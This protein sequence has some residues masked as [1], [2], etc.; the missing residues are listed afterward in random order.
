M[1]EPTSASSTASSPVYHS[2][3]AE[4]YGFGIGPTSLTFLGLGV[5]AGV[6]AVIIVVFA[7]TV[8][9]N[10]V[11]ASMKAGQGDPRYLR[12]MRLYPAMIGGVCLTI[13]LFWFAWST[14]EGVHWMCPVVAEAVYGLGN[15]LVFMSA[16]LYLM[17]FYG[18]MY[19]ASAMA[20][21]TLIRYV[22]GA[23]FPLFI[24]PMFRNLG[25]GWAVSI[26]WVHQFAV[27]H[28]ALYVLHSGTKAAED[29]QVCA[30]QLNL[31]KSQGVC[32]CTI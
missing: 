22:I 20:G 25:I 1:S 23:I 32:K 27:G 2:S 10:R 31:K 11:V 16:S 19:G 24:E 26:L 3:F 30:V 28:G 6:G 4:K 21:N 5:G 13:S 8:F 17:D 12:E 7:K 14:Q 18:P 29:E 9:K 15:F